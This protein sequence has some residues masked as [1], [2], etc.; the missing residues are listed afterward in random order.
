MAVPENLCSNKCQCCGETQPEF[1]TLDHING[2]GHKLAAGCF[3]ETENAKE[4]EQIL[5]N[6]VKKTLQIQQ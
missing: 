4:A 5:L 6:H 1:L 3:I 2:G